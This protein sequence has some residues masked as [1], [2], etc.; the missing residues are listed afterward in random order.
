MRTLNVRKNVNQVVKWDS[1]EHMIEGLPIF[2]IMY[3]GQPVNE[4]LNFDGLCHIRFYY[5]DD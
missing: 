5:T 4:E 2:N 3:C 1:N